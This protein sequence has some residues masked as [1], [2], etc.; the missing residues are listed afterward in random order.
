MSGRLR[1]WNAPP[2]SLMGRKV[3]LA[4]LGSFVRRVRNEVCT[5]GDWILFLSWLHDLL[6]PNS[7][8]NTLFLG[9]KGFTKWPSLPFFT[10]PPFF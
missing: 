5:D 2:L 4:G 1:T 10:S 3:V 9:V 6:P 7:N 8:P